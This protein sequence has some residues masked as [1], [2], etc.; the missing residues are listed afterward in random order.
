MGPN[1]NLTPYQ[2]AELAL[3][4]EEI[5]REK[6][7]ENQQ[8]GGGDQKSGSVN[9]RKPIPPIHTDI[10]LARTAGV[11]KDTITAKSQDRL[12]IPLPFNLNASTHIDTASTH[13]DTA[14]INPNM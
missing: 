2:R 12:V 1:H 6:A 10:E 5:F 11:G 8:A 7:K 9:S 3:K 14:S 13:I 4:L